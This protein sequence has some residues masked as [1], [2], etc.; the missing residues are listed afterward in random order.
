MINNTLDITLTQKLLNNINLSFNN[1]NKV[2][3]V[4]IILKAKLKN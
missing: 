3:I 1:K 4:S 2:I